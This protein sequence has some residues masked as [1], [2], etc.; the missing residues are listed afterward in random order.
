MRDK[1]H[2]LLG[3]D[4]S[5]E[6]RRAVRWPG[7]LPLT[8]QWAQGSR[9]VEV[10]DFNAQG[11]RFEGG[12]G[13]PS[14][15][16]SGQTVELQRSTDE[17]ALARLVWLRTRGKEQWSG[18]VLFDKSD[19]DNWVQRLIAEQQMRPNHR[20]AVR[21]STDYPVVARAAG[22]NLDMRIL[23]LSVQG[24]RLEAPRS[25]APGQFLEL[26]L[27][28]GTI[29]AEVRRLVQIRDCYQLGVRFQAQAAEAE[30]LR[31]WVDRLRNV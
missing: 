3:H 13:L 30:Q 26:F 20:A 19:R 17:G 25:V 22:E 27:F 6:R 28:G 1:I 21:V 8:L 23:D 12:G 7:Q 15:L 5:P 4:D 2:R 16:H 18:A 24:A 10:A 11:L 31:N 14:G 9:M 29:S